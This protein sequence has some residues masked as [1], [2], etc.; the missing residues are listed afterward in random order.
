MNY[1][2][3][4]SEEAS[5]E[6]VEA[7]SWYEE[8]SEGLGERFFTELDNVIALLKINPWMFPAV[9]KDFHQAPLQVFPYVIVYMIQ[10]EDVLIQAVFHAKRNPKESFLRKN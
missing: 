6:I 8:R 4:F 3:E 10:K 9:Y 5:S 7:Y 2:V 1:Q